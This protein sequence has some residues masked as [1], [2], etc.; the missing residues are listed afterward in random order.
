MPMIIIQAPAED[1]E[2]FEQLARQ[3]AT[4]E[5]FEP[6]RFEGLAEIVQVA[7][8]LSVALVRTLVPYFKEQTERA[9]NRLVIIDGTKI[10]LNGY[11]AEEV[12][13]ILT[14]SLPK[15]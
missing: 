5:V 1:K 13:A 3:G 4:V 12:E 8:T 9:K 10:R 14:K 15:E 11:T 6:E 2:F 7:V